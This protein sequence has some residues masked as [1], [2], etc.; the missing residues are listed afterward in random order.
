MPDTD[1]L[2]TDELARVLMSE[3]RRGWQNP[4]KVVRAIGVTRGMVVADLGCG[5]GFFTIPLASAVGRSGLVYGVDSNAGMLSYLR[6][7]LEK[8]GKTPIGLVKLIEADV[9]QT[10]IPSG[11]VDVAFF[12]NILHDLTEPSKFLREVRRMIKKDSIIVD[13][14]WEKKESGFGPPLEIRLSAAQSKEILRGGGFKV[15]G[16][17]YAGRFHYGLVCRSI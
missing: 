15:V 11:T 13:I 4:E 16:S 5:P 6:D 12:A 9:A 1:K 8:I 14:D 2:G 7:N 10:D 3:E 17:V